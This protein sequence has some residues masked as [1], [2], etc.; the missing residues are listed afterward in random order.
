MSCLGRKR[1][2]G[3]LTLLLQ[4][5]SQTILPTLNVN[6]NNVDTGVSTTVGVNGTVE[7]VTLTDG[8]SVT[9]TSG[10]QYVSTT[11][12]PPTD[13]AIAIELPVVPA[14]SPTTTTPSTTTINGVIVTDNGDGTY[15][16]SLPTDAGGSQTISDNG[17]GAAVVNVY[18]AGGALVG[19]EATG[20]DANACKRYKKRSC[21]RTYLLG[22]RPKTYLKT[23]KSC[24]KPPS[25]GAKKAKNSS[26]VS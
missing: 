2:M 8:S 3:D 10:N 21:L 7:T 1:E 9:L 22:C 13:S 25:A 17:N 19:S 24:A 6:V 4:S 16:Y 12:A 23:A 14:T 5:L 26:K 11:T 18:T 20:F 15:A